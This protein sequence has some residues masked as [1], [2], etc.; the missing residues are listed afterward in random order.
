MNT[1]TI[2]TQSAPPTQ[3]LRRELKAAEARRRTMALLLV[4]P[5]AIFLLLV[6]VVPIGALLTRAVQ[7]PEIATALPRTVAAL[8]NWDR[9]AAPADAAYAALASDLTQVADGEAM[10]AL[11]RRLN[12]EIPGYRSLVAKTA[13]AMPLTGDANAPLAPAQTRAKLIEL[14]ER[15]GDAAYWQA[16]AKN[17]G[18]YSPFYLLAALDHKQDGFGSIVPADPDQSIY[19]AVFGRT[20][21]IGFAVTLF[22]LALGYPL[23][24]WIS[25]LPE[26]RANLA[27]I[28]VLIPFWTSVLVRV[29]AWIVLLQSEGLVN[30][31]LIDTG[32]ISQPLALLFN[33]VGVYIS[34]TH[35]LLPFMILP[36]YSVMKSIPPS[37]QRAAVSLGSHPFA[38]FWRVYVPQTYPGVGAGALLVFILAIGYYITPALLGGPNDQMVSYYVAYFTNVTINWGMACALGGLLLAATLVLYAIYGRFTRSQLSLG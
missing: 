34:M 28:L 18:R 23:A 31:A 1:M 9:K 35:I 29:A 3:S 32:L 17:G 24:Y 36:L 8:S 15:W 30:R 10:G 38:A 4:A 25:T 21:L 33:R 7:N 19:L 20:L 5:L 6:F 14:D 13:R 37:Y 26:R 16:I 22:A 12:T 2:A 27:M 11:A